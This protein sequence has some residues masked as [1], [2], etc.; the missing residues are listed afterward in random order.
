MCFLC[1]FIQTIQLR[2]FVNE[3]VGYTPTFRAL[4][5]LEFLTEKPAT[6]ND[7]LTAVYKFDHIKQ[8][9]LL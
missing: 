2:L 3:C 7:L 4:T 6:V 9:N 1:V 8:L 5:V